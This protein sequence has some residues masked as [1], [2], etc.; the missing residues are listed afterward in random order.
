[1]IHALQKL[2]QSRACLTYSFDVRVLILSTFPAKHPRHGGQI[3]MVQLAE[4]YN[5]AGWQVTVSGVYDSRYFPKD[6]R[7]VP[8]KKLN[9]SP[10]WENIELAKRVEQS[11]PLFDQLMRKVG[12]TPDVIQVEHPWLFRIAQ[13][14]SEYG[15]GR[16]ALVYSSHNQETYLSRRTSEMK[17]R[18]SDQKLQE[19]VASREEEAVLKSAGV[20]CVSDHDA[21]YFKAQGARAVLVAENGPGS[22]PTLG[23]VGPEKLTTKAEKYALFVGSAHPPNVDGLM[24]F[25]SGYI[26]S[27][28]PGEKIVVAGGVGHLLNRD[29]RFH[30]SHLQDRA[31][32]LGE[33]SSSALSNLISGAQT[34]LLPQRGGAGTSLKTAEAL[35]ASK[36]IVAS[37]DAMRGFESYSSLPFVHVARTPLEFKFALGEAMTSESPAPES[38]DRSKIGWSY[39]LA[40][41]PNFLEQ[42]CEEGFRE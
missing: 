8:I 26:G 36:P 40:G 18:Y 9:A 23:S 22:S 29:Q 10:G 27:L 1:M 17:G 6:K 3:R 15:G 2:S 31:R 7:Y 12:A 20:I 38:W 41:A 42:L 4:R 5:A 11:E 39:R 25:L 28:R 35:L 37:E 16:A 30:G 13:R 33:V 14:I 21:T 34:I 32:I 24:Y 19:E